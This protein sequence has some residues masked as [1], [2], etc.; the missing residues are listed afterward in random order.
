[1][2][3][4]N[5]SENNET[6]ESANED[7]VNTENASTGVGTMSSNEVNHILTAPEPEIPEESGRSKHKRVP[8]RLADALNGYLCGLVLNSSSGGVLKCKQAGCETRWVSTLY[9]GCRSIF[10]LT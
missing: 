10:R 7:S 1:M 9:S 3:H 8:R 4:E 2:C 5:G 6:A